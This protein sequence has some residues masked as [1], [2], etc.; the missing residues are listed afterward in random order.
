MAF[1]ETNDP[2]RDMYNTM[3]VMKRKFIFDNCGA[4]GQA[5]DDTD[6]T[7]K[8]CPGCGKPNGMQP[9]SPELDIDANMRRIRMLVKALQPLHKPSH[10]AML[11][12]ATDGGMVSQ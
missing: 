3:I 4:V 7:G 10:P 8:R 1:I 12:S 5:E 11:D 6:H 2:E 9:S